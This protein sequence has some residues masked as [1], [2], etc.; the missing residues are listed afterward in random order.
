MSRVGK[1]PVVVPNGVTVTVANS[2]VTVEG[3][4]G[5]LTQPVPEEITVTVG[6]APAQSDDAS[7]ATVV[8]VDRTG[9]S[10]TH[11]SLHGLTRAL[12]SN[13]CVGVSDGYSK[14]LDIVGVGYRVDQPKEFPANG[15]ANLVLALGFSHPVNVEAPEGI[16]FDVPDQTTIHVIGHDK[17]LVGQMA[18]NIRALRKPEPY[19][20]K[21][22]RYAGERVI[23]KAG[24]AAK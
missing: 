5:V 11:R 18:A 22:I 20:G 2:V 3:P 21:G 6:S 14:E 7:D 16:S 12:I 10:R 23:R 15:I 1:A 13:M 9:D 8:V 19:K 17:Q 4:K 24:K